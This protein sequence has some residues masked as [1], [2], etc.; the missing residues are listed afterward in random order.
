MHCDSSR[1]Q[2]W[3][4]CSSVQA[5][6]GVL[7]QLFMAVSNTGGSSETFPLIAPQVFMFFVQICFPIASSLHFKLLPTCTVNILFAISP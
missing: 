2:Y 1:D 3:K 7:I 6:P 4:L 5:N